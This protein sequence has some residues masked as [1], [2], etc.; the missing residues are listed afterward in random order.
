MP[1]RASEGTMASYFNCMFGYLDAL[2]DKYLANLTVD[3][4]H[5]KSVIDAPAVVDAPAQA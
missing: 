5:D 4:D 2:R 1:E 3:A